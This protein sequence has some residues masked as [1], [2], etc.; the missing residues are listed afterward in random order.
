MLKNC[1]FPT[2]MLEKTLESP[3]DCKI[4]PD[5]SLEGLI[6]KLKLQ[7]FDHLLRT[8]NCCWERLR[9][10]GEGGNGG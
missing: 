8:D 7:Y 2:V 1:C 6:L 10:G 9:E 4:N 5:Y 3:L